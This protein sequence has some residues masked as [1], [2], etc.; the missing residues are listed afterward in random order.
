MVRAIVLLSGGLDS[1]TTAYIAKHRGYELH[2][3]SFDYGQRH[4]KELESSKKIAKRLGID[5]R[6]I[7]IELP[8]RSDA[9]TGSLSVP[10]NREI[11]KE[12][13]VTYV[14]ARNT[15]FIA[16]A[17]S[18]SEVIDA[19]AIFIGANA[20]DFSGYPDCT[21]EYIEAWNDLIKVGMKNN[22]V[23]VVAPLIDMNKAEIIKEGAKL[24]APFELTWSCYEGREKACGVCDSCMLRLKGFKEAGLKDPIEYESQEADR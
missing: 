19:D 6:I 17:L 3:L 20:I 14:P 4:K 1:C 8:E 18:W 2:A 5:H 7:R 13:P 21:K 22:G 24:G 16:Y 9:L 12:I 23:R 10:H 15:I 11:G